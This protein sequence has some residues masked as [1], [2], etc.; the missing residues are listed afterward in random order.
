MRGR[1]GRAP[2][3]IGA[4]PKQRDAGSRPGGP[5]AVD[6]RNT[7]GRLRIS[8]TRKTYR[9]RP[10]AP[11]RTLE[12]GDRVADPSRHENRARDSKRLFGSRLAAAEQ[13][14][15][16][17]LKGL[18][19]ERCV[20]RIDGLKPGDAIRVPGEKASTV[21]LASGRGA[22][23]RAVNDGAA[24]QRGPAN[25]K[26]LPS[27]LGV[28]HARTVVAQLRGEL[29]RGLLFLRTGDGSGAVTPWCGS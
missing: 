29:D 15:D 28:D 8:G 5:G 4:A 2:V 22:R 7:S 6:R 26:K 23:E 10:S 16:S 13:R 24:W 12:G 27:A 21:W 14:L 19:R 1:E 9:Q 17:G 20:E 18:R 11:S 25:E 3:G